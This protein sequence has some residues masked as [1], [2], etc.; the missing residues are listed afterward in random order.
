[1][2]SHVYRSMPVP[3]NTTDW[4]PVQPTVGVTGGSSDF[5]WDKWLTPSGAI[6]SKHGQVRCRYNIEVVASDGSVSFQTCHLMKTPN[7]YHSRCSQCLD[8]TYHRPSPCSR[9][10]PRCVECSS[11][12]IL[13]PSWTWIE[14]RELRKST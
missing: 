4:R 9:D 11:W 14:A 7:D 1:M 10:G 12:D 2:T 5:N 13:H 6:E 3:A 8:N